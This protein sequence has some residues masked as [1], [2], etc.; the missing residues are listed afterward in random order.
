M[1]V[2]Y[3][4]IRFFCKKKP[5]LDLSFSEYFGISNDKLRTIF[6]FIY[7]NYFFIWLKA[8]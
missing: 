4:I 5:F 1:Q 3:L 2:K 6:T 7:L 8:R